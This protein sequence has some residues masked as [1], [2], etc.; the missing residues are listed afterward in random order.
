MCPDAG[1]DVAS[2]GI[3]RHIAPAA[4]VLA[5]LLQYQVRYVIKFWTALSLERLVA[6]FAFSTWRTQSFVH[7]SGAGTKCASP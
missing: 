3:K 7:F 6:C 2:S 1:V 5:S 4:S